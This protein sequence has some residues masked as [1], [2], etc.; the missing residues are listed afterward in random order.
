MS[1]NRSFP[2]P[3][4]V[5]DVETTGLSPWHHDRIIEI[6][7]VIM[8]P[9]GHIQNEYESLVNPERDVGPTRIHRITAGEVLHAPKFKEIAGDILDL[10]RSS[11][12]VAGHNISFDRNF[13]VK[14][15][16][17]IGITFPEFT[18]LCTCQMLGRQNL[19]VCCNE[20]GIPF[21]GEPHY[22][23]HDARA[24]AHL[25]HALIDQ[26]SGAFEQIQCSQ[27]EWPL[28][29]PL[30][31]TPVTRRAAQENLSQPPHFL[32]RIGSKLHHDV[33]TSS[34]EILAYLTVVDRFLEDRVLDV[35]EAATLVDVAMQLNL[36]ARDVYTAHQNY[37]HNLAAHAL[38]DGVITDTERNDLYEVAALL[39]Y[40]RIELDAALNVAE[41][42]LKTV[43]TLVSAAAKSNDLRGKT[44]CFTGEL[45]SNLA[46]QPI[47]RDEAEA[48][49]EKAGLIVAS[50]VTKK[51]DL[52]IVADPNTQSGKAKKARQY[53]VRILAE[54]AFWRMIGVIVE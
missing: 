6:G 21:D 3:I 7:I 31:T 9:D 29:T 1:Q 46:G 34:Y 2:D 19:E 50:T 49:A 39:G 30:G 13:L 45:Q 14:E 10:L 16:E 53:G 47:T 26:D 35:N 42:Q 15:Y 8:S 43:A 48:I 24:A 27:I 12:L 51:L 54:P 37:I 25:V 23:I 36:N 40:D 5:V 38:A 33:E 20:F 28:L 52:L 17:R 4:A 32:K 11:K 41:T 44:V 22:A 18:C